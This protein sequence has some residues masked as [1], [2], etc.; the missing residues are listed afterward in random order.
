MYVIAW[1]SRA[2]VTPSAPVRPAESTR[3]D[4]RAVRRAPGATSAVSSATS[5][6]RG[7]MPSPIVS[8]LSSARISATA[9]RP[10]SMSLP[11]SVRNCSHSRTSVDASC[12][13]R[14]LSSQARTLERAKSGLLVPPRHRGRKVLV[15]PAPIGDGRTRDPRQPGDLGG[16]DNSVGAVRACGLILHACQGHA[17]SGK[18]SEGMCWRCK[19][20]V[21]AWLSVPT[22]RRPGPRG[23]GPEP[24]CSRRRPRPGGGGPPGGGRRGRGPGPCRGGG[25]GCGPR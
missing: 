12:P 1:M 24:R 7:V 4:T 5:W 6:R 22:A 19:R 15:T 10:P 3:R 9:D 14:W 25:G 20:V 16:G 8:R 13:L 18:G 23:R 2:D 17:E 11:Y 21:R